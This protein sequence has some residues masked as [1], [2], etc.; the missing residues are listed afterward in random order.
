[1]DTY[2]QALALDNYMKNKSDYKFVPLQPKFNEALDIRL[3]NKHDLL[4]ESLEKWKTKFDDPYMNEVIQTQNGNL[5][6]ILKQNIP[7]SEYYQELDANKFKQREL[8]TGILN[9]DIPMGYYDKRIP[10]SEIRQY[11]N[12]NSNDV[13]EIPMY[14][15]Q[16]LKD[17]MFKSDPNI[18]YDESGNAFIPQQ[19]TVSIPKKEEKRTALR[20][21][22]VMEP[23][24]NRPGKYRVKELRQVPYSDYA[25]GNGWSDVIAP[26]VIYVDADGNETEER[27][28]LIKQKQGGE[29]D[30]FVGGGT[31]TCP[32]NSYWDDTS[33][34]CIECT[35][36]RCVETD[37]VQQILDKGSQIPYENLGVM[38]D[39]VKQMDQRQPFGNAAK[40]WKNKGAQSL[41]DRLGMDDLPNCMWATGMGYQCLPETKGQMSLTPFESND[42]FIRAVN[43]GKIPFERVT[44]TTDP[45]FDDQSKGILHPG[46]IVNV[47]G[48]GT[49]HALT[50]SH[51]RNDGTPIFLDSNGHPSDFGWN[52][53]MWEDLRPGNGR[54]A[55]VSRFSPEMFYEKQ[56]KNLE[57]K[58]RTNPTI[59]HE[60]ESIPYLKTLPAQPIEQQL[61]PQDRLQ[62][63]GALNKFV[64][65]PPDNYDPN[66]A[67]NNTVFLKS[68]INSPLFVERYARMVGKSIEEVEEE[69]EVY[70][71]QMIQNLQTVS[72]GDSS[73]PPF[74]YESLNAA[75]Y[76]T[77]PYDI[78][79]SNS[80]VTEIQNMIDSVP[81]RGKYNKETRSKYQYL[82]DDYKSKVDKLNSV[83]HKLYFKNWDKAHDLHERSHASTKGRNDIKGVYDYNYRDMSKPRSDSFFDNLEHTVWSDYYQRENK[84]TQDKEY[85]DDGTVQSYYSQLTEL[86]ARKDVA[87]KKLQELG[88]Y[89]PVNENFT[90]EH[91]KKLIDLMRN[92]DLDDNTRMQIRDIV[93][94]FT[95]EDTI[96]MFNDIVQNEPN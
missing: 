40:I 17:E 24:P 66:V 9:M 58:A 49:S 74:S 88:L 19:K 81:N 52:K 91:Y 47:K 34:T 76:Y 80:K 87:A 69:A 75:A 33:Q 15:Q 27:P 50:F 55:Y 95:K 41:G 21:Q 89:D 44:K 68:M 46:D 45:L 35:D 86:K 57:E 84:N 18:Q 85:S 3:A 64:G 36:E 83:G 96:K 51:Y 12:N 10:I 23:D 60:K 28:G 26:R 82:L 61:Q 22:T 13:V 32:P 71:Q 25:E 1:M 29:L 37:Q 5:K 16:Y 38:W 4:N 42:K 70:R 31:N 73:N 14:D 54:S 65:G 59:I 94:P 30:K 11:K 53:G 2:N 72:M 79:E 43:E 48:S 63:G 8:S 6:T 77:P 78:E 62:F 92:P 93:T 56:I 67:E 39:V 20:S 90:E 7:I